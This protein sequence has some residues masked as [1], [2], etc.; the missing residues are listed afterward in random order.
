M[1]GRINWLGLWTLYMKE[2]RR[3]AKIWTQTIG[4]PAVTTLLFMTIF[5]L[6]LGGA[7]RVVGDVPF[8]TFLAPGLIAMSIIQNSFQN[9]S[10][11][12]LVGKVQ[13]NIIDVLMPPLSAGEL[14]LGYTAGAATRG[15]L[16]GAT[17]LLAFSFAPNME[18]SITHWWAVLYFAASASIMLGLVGILTGIW[19]AKFDHSAAITNFIVNPLSLLSGTFYS[20]ERLPENWRVVSEFNPFFYLIDGL[21]YG[22]I[23]TADGNL[24]TG[25][26]VTLALNIALWAATHH[27]FAKGYRIKA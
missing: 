4:A 8:Q 3:F 14:T 22:F 21:R 13:G 15:L 19:A 12:I 27:A 10:S 16:V 7:G 24:S 18:T 17:V 23:G 11:S 25:I 2:V 6:A 5:S 1:I 9:S 20:I 26:A